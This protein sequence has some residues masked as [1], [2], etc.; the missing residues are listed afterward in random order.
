MQYFFS[1]YYQQVIFQ[2]ISSLLTVIVFDNISMTSLGSETPVCR[3]YC[4]IFGNKFTEV[5]QNRK[6]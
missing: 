1:L 5:L 6:S 3:F 4:L 2:H